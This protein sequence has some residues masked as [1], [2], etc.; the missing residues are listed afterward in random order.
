MRLPQA[1]SDADVD[2]GLVFQDVQDHS[3]TNA[4]YQQPVQLLSTSVSPVVQQSVLQQSEV[5]IVNN[6]TIY[7]VPTLGV[8]P[9][10]VKAPPRTSGL[11]GPPSLKQG[12][13]HMC[14]MVG[15]DVSEKP[16]WEVVGRRELMPA[17]QKVLSDMDFTTMPRG[18]DVII[19]VDGTVIAGV[20]SSAEVRDMLGGDNG[21]VKTVVVSRLGKILEFRLLCNCSYPAIQFLRGPPH[22][23]AAG[24]TCPNRHCLRLLIPRTPSEREEER[25]IV[26]Q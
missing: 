23:V 25:E 16:P 3:L 20:E 15:L 22:V 6:T 9:D 26:K 2:A 24:T 17:G 5:N 11:V 7:Q 12:A 1:E 14:A 8:L 18:G 4:N 21:Q 13:L 10:N 19:S